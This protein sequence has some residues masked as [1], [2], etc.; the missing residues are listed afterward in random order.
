MRFS[1]ILSGMTAVTFSILLPV[2]AGAR[3]LGAHQHGHGNVNIA[4]ED[5]V[6]WVE[7]IAPGADIVGFE[8]EATTDEDKEALASAKATLSDPLTVLS[9]P[10][11]AGCEPQDV[12]VEVRSE[13][14]DHEH[15][16]EDH[17][18]HD[19]EHADED[20]DQDEHADE[21]HDDEHHDGEGEEHG[22][23][24][25]FHVEYSLVCAN[26]AALDSIGF[27]NFDLF[28]GAEELDVTVLNDGGQQHF[29]VT[30]DAPSIALGN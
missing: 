24:S 16:D 23:H 5:S 8:H 20:H 22:G 19:R 9:L 12:M 21:D 29:E 25:E 28:V 26:P 7:M 30:A 4:M 18:D 3:E 6:L 17:D 15:A 10:D 11:A 13:H 1:T 2:G 27:N 14:H